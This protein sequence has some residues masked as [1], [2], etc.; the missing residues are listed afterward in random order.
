MTLKLLGSNFSLKKELFFTPLIIV[1]L[2]SFI[3]STLKDTTGTKILICLISIIVPVIIR[4][5][6]N[7]KPSY[8]LLLTFPFLI[9]GIIQTVSLFEYQ[10]DL[11]INTWEVI[12]NG[13]SEE[14]VSFLSELK[15][16]TISLVLFKIIIYTLYFIILK[17]NKNLDVIKKRRKFWL[18]LGII[19]VID[20]GFN[21]A[22]RKIFPFNFVE[23]FSDFVKEKIKERQYFSK[24][25]EIVFNAKRNDKLFD[26]KE[27]ET[28]VV[29]VGESLRRD[30]LEYYGYNKETTPLLKN[31]EL[32][33]YTDVISPA[34]QSVISLKR[35]FSYGEYKDINGYLKYPSLL[36]VFK[37]AGF[38]T[39]WLSTQRIYG[40]FDSEISYIAKEADEVIF[41]DYNGLDEQLFKPYKKVLSK[42]NNK[43]IIFLHIMGNHFSYKK[44]THS[45]FFYFD[46]NNKGNKKEQLINQYDDSVRYNDFVLSFFLNELKKIKGEKSFLMFSDHG[47]SLFDSGENL[48]FHSSIKPSKSEFNIP[49]VLWLSKEIKV[50][51]PNRYQQIIKNKD[52]PIIL[53]D[54]FHALPFLY[55]IEFPKLNKEKAFFNKTY[56]PVLNRKVLNPERNI[57]KYDKLISKKN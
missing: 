35:I 56:V 9:I 18:V 2:S 43:K 16:V 41:E 29:I 17:K 52:K 8:F 48:A 6:F 25:K 49:L 20:F 51:Y 47:E 11:S 39:Y 31:E 15:T 42:K 24:K 44:R 34:N 36:K 40:F 55:G 14:A 57:L 13:N 50:N 26:I 32:I 33:C 22:T 53:S 23:S 12:F 38:K 5:V 46:N 1:I 10:S 19:L 21:G 28:I 4:N 30:H 7:L 54:F 3:W 45:D 37:E 27:K